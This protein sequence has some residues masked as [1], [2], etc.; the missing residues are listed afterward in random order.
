MK[1][2]YFQFLISFFLFGILNKWGADH[3]SLLGYPVSPLGKG[4]GQALPLQSRSTQI[5]DFIIL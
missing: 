4:Q 3:I 2:N 5:F 1:F